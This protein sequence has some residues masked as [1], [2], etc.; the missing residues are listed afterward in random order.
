MTVVEQVSL[1]SVSF[2]LRNLVH[3]GEEPVDFD[4]SL[5]RTRPLDRIPQVDAS[6]SS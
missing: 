3:G 4:A 2:V 5:D 1:D 6:V